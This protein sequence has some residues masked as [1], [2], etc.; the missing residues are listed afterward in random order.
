MLATRQTTSGRPDRRRDGRMWA[1]EW[2]GRVMCLPPPSASAPHLNPP[3]Q[4]QPS[5]SPSFAQ[6][7]DPTQATSPRLATDLARCECESFS[8]GW[9]AG[10]LCVRLCAGGRASACKRLLLGTFSTKTPSNCR[11]YFPCN[12]KYLAHDWP[13]RQSGR[14]VAD[15]LALSSP[16][17]PLFHGCSTKGLP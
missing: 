3:A 14:K 13:R 2:R 4:P 7:T 16:V 15:S 17:Y 10:G 9:A 1:R 8:N 12:I 6:P 5:L 11:C